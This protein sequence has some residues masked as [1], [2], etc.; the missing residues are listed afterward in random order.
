MEVTP[1]EQAS[2]AAYLPTAAWIRAFLKGS[3]L[4][5]AKRDYSRTLVEGNLPG[6][7]TL[8]VPILGGSA[9]IKRLPL[10][11]LRISAHGDWT[12]IHLGALEAA[13]GREPYFQHYFPHIAG[14]ISAYPPLLADMNRALLRVL[15]GPQ[16]R[17]STLTALRSLR[18][19][20]PERTAQIGRRLAANADPA[21]S[22]IEPLFRFGPDSFFLLLDYE[23]I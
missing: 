2:T 22:F 13:Y 21:H 8:S 15:L 19:R 4:Q 14:I 23:N 3:P 10:T 9:A 11:E 12:R 6:G 1:Q 5:M 16:E 20:H 17:Q 18:E 7:Q